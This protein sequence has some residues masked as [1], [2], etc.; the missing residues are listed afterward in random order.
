MR[1]LPVG[2]ITPGMILARPARALDGSLLYKPGLVLEAKQLGWLKQ[3][4][5]QE[6]W[7]VPA[8]EPVPDPTVPEYLD[9]YGPDFA[10][11]L[12]GTFAHALVNRTMQ[13][14]F[15]AALAHATDCYRRYRVDEGSEE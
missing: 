14:L 7:V 15:L 11:K 5:L 2:D 1:C 4:G 6:L 8:G 3:A 9:R 10:A 12:Q 13:N